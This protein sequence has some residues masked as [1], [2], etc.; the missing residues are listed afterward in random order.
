MSDRF[1]ITNGSEYAISQPGGITVTTDKTMAQIF[2]KA[3]SA[4][5]VATE[6]RKLEGFYVAWY[7]TEEMAGT[8]PK[9]KPFPPR[10]RTAVYQKT[11]GICAIC[12][13][14][15]SED[16]FTI[17][18]IIPL[19]KGGTDDISNLQPACRACNEIKNNFSQEELLDKIWQI[20]VF[21]MKSDSF[22]LR[23]ISNC[24][25]NF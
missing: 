4:W 9:R 5:A 13:D 1:I 3:K 22:R 21:N 2:R 6:C 7:D 15:I 17:D 24:I 11:N 14:S 20:L 25:D 23:E 8:A 16:N 10:I 18:H 12:G 19:S